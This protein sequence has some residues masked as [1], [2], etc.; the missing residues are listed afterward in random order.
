MTSLIRRLYSTEKCAKE[1]GQEISSPQQRVG[2]NVFELLQEVEI[3]P[4]F[5]EFQNFV[6]V[7]A[8][9][10]GQTSNIV[11]GTRPTTTDNNFGLAQDQPVMPVNKQFY[12]KSIVC[13]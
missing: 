2:W 9:I 7:N 3:L 5:N 8:T 13:D 10:E 6:A 1:S 12:W 4:S 11:V